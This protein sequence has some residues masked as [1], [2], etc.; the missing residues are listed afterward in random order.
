MEH[1]WGRRLVS[2]IPVR[3]RCERSPDSGCRCLGCVVDLSASGASIRTELGI[4]PAARIRIET[5]TPAGGLK[6]QE[7]PACIVR[8]KPGEIAIEWAEFASPAVFALMAETMLTGGTDPVRAVPALGRVRF[9][10]LA[11]ATNWDAPKAREPVLQA[12]QSCA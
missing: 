11:P 5:L 2:G 1:R 4:C 9:C 7:V 12:G 6:P 10:A 3:L 8:A